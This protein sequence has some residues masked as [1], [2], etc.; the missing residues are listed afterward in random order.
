MMSNEMELLKAL[1]HALNFDIHTNRDYEERVSVKPPKSTYGL[2]QDRIAVS[3]NT[4]AYVRDEDGLYT[5]RLIT[6]KI[7]YQLSKTTKPE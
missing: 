2:E 6:P 7:T 4:G 5:T 3:D 1:C